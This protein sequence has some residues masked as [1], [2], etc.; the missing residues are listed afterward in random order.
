MSTLSL[1]FESI[2]GNTEFTGVDVFRWGQDGL[3]ILSSA[4]N[5]YLVRG[6]GNR[7]GTDE[8]ELCGDPDFEFNC[9]GNA[10]GGQHAAHSDGIELP[11]GRSRN[12]ERKVSDYDYR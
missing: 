3:A 1:P 6:W 4:G 11:S 5:V 12:V 2:E 7:T 10:W 8:R 9:F